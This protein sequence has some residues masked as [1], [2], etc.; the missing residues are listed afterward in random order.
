MRV[1]ILTFGAL[2][3]LLE[4]PGRDGRAENVVLGFAS[5]DDYAADTSYFGA[6]VG[7]FA[8]RIAAGQFTVDGVTC[9]VPLNEGANS[10]HG[11]SE[12]FDRRIWEASPVEQADSVGVRL[13]LV[14]PDGD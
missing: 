5:V 4:A 14:S 3:Q 12:G 11:G 8:N 13:R 2:I 10:L 1:G 9:Q 6:T 7:R